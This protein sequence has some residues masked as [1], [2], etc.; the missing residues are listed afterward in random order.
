MEILAIA[1]A[2]GNDGL[3]AELLGRG[4][5]VGKRREGKPGETPLFSAAA[6]GKEKCVRALLEAGADPDVRTSDQNPRK[7]W[8]PLMQAAQQGNGAVVGTLLE[9]GAN[10]HLGDKKNGV[11][12]LEFATRASTARRI[13]PHFGGPPRLRAKGPTARL[14]LRL[15]L[16][17]G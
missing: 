3:V 10:P 5:S 7:G 15:A 4:A 16:W 6:A 14:V 2:Q 8:T 17:G 12:A 9:F 1:A 13:V 11:T